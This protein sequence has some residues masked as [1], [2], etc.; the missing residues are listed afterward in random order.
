MAAYSWIVPHQRQ[1]QH[2]DDFP[3]LKRWFETLARRAAVQRAYDVRK[4]IN[5][6]TGMNDSA[7]SILF[8]R[9]TAA[10][11]NPPK[12]QPSRALSGFESV[13]L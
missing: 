10:T 6:S 13:F 1:G 7:K 8:G 11:L 5:T 12:V 2:L 4:R 3:N 9:P